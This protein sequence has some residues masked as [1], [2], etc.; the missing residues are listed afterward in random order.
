M[1]PRDLS[2]RSNSALK[3]QRGCFNNNDY[4]QSSC[5]PVLNTAAFYQSVQLSFFSAGLEET[6][7]V[8]DKQ[9]SNFLLSHR[10]LMLKRKEKNLSG[11][12]TFCYCLPRT[13]N[14]QGWV[15]AHG[16]AR[17]RIRDSLPHSHQP[18]NESDTESLRMRVPAAWVAVR[19]WTAPEQKNGASVY[20]DPRKV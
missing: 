7:T 9:I 1:I 11:W 17:T 15:R 5:R 6:R 16:L 18:I 20:S 14:F 13:G 8:K 2:H 4:R 19:A 3:S 12:C 10:F